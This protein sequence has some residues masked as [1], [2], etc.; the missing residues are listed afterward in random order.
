[1]DCA[2]RSFLDFTIGVVCL[3]VTGLVIAFFLYLY[4]TRKIVGQFA[5]RRDLRE[6]QPA[7]ALNGG[8]FAAVV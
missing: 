5:A 3:F 8:G 2:E 7:R 1:M 6:P 4:K